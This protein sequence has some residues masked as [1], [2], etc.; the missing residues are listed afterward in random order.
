MKDKILAAGGS[1]QGI[2]EI[3]EHIRL[4]Y[5]TVWEI[6]QKIVI[7]QSAERGPYVC[8]S[9][10]LNIHLEDPDFA[11]MTNVHF[12]GWKK[13]LKTGMYYLR[14]RPKAKITAF[15]LDPTKQNQNTGN[16]STSTKQQPSEEEIMACRRDNP[17]GCV[18]CSG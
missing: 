16:A 2:P 3:P 8:Q 14:S 11:K 10:S 15:T 1:V 17:E 5:K 4:L 9:Q 13:G 7:D 18:M 12:Y 6:K